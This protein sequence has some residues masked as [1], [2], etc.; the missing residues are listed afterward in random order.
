M[1]NNVKYLS[2]GVYGQPDAM[3]QSATGVAFRITT[4]GEVF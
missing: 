4:K 2:E 3:M 1:V